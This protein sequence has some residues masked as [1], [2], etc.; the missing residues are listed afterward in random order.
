MQEVDHGHTRYAG[1]R[2]RAHPVSAVLHAHD[3]DNEQGDEGDANK[4]EGGK[5]EERHRLLSW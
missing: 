2:P 3:E 5:D 4:D 1:G